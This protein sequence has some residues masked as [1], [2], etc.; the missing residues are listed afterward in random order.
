MSVAQ[1]TL[2]AGSKSP[3]ATRA[4]PAPA[5]W[6]SGAGWK[7]PQNCFQ[8]QILCS[9]C[10]RTTGSCMCVLLLVKRAATCVKSSPWSWRSSSL[11][12][13]LSTF[14]LIKC[15]R[16]RKHEWGGHCVADEDQKV[17]SSL[18]GLPCE[19]CA[20]V[21]GSLGLLS[22]PL[23]Q[24]WRVIFL[25]YLVWK[26][27]LRGLA[28][29]P[30]SQAKARPSPLNCYW[31]CLNKFLLSSHASEQCFGPKLSSRRKNALPTI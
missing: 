25:Q 29:F 9:L 23:A 31:F 10:H 11:L 24:E 5:S 15:H 27:G 13:L 30:T 19:T 28:L 6:V 16:I 18:V 26:M 4:L 12:H 3:R 7:G 8:R 21:L 1:C 14:S 17:L 2:N 20:V 22:S